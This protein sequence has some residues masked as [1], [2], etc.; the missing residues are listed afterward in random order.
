MVPAWL[1]TREKGWLLK[2]GVA[3]HLAAA[4]VLYNFNVIAPL[5]GIEPGDKMDPMRRVRGWDALGRSL[6]ELRMTMPGARLL[7]D[8]RKAM[9]TLVYYVRPH[10]FEARMWMP[11]EHPGNHYQLEMALEEGDDGPFLYV[12]QREDAKAITSRFAEAE[13]ISVL[14]VALSEEF[15]VR[16]NVWRV[17]GF[18]GYAES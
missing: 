16:L 1:L 12:T 8:E 13:Q 9:A 18:K 10:P 3:I 2:A 15:A 4:L 7:F 6:S 17:N 5:V 14:R 11:L